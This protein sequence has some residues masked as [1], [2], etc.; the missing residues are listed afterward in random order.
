MPLL[1]PYNFIQKKE[2]IPESM[3][4]SSYMPSRQCLDPQRCADP[5]GGI[6]AIFLRMIAYC[7]GVTW[8]KYYI[9]WGIYISVLRVKYRFIGFGIFVT[10]LVPIFRI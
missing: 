5:W 4:T 3:Q 7:D 1:M 8:Y 2:R 10:I 9:V 6:Q